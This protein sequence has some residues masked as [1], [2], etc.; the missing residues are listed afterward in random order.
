M[1]SLTPGLS[2]VTDAGQTVK[3]RFN[4][5]MIA[6][7]KPLKRFEKFARLINTPLKQGVNENR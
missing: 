2:R 5:F 4:G 1:L 7:E 6:P 3:I